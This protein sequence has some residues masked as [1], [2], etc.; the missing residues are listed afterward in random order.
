MRSSRTRVSSESNSSNWNLLILIELHG[1]LLAEIRD[2]Q[3]TSAT[4]RISSSTPTW[5]AII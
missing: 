4:S 5:I 1:Q 2:L 3:T